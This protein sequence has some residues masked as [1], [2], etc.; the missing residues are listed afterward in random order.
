MML[1]DV[2]VLVGANRVDHPHHAVCFAWLRGATTGG[3]PFAV[4]PLILSAVVR[5]LTSRRIFT[6]PT[7]LSEAFRYCD[8]L[9]DHPLARI[10]EPGARH[11][12]IFSRLCH[13]TGTVGPKISDAW[14]A[15]LAIEHGCEWIS[16]DRDF[17]AYPDLRWRSPAPQR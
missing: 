9:L 4:T 12:T 7:T 1:A 13:Q 17:A 15:A 3:E 16:L 5:I 6:E 11:W 14:Y 2:N 10:I 8:E